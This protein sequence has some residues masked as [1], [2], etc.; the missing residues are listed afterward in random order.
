MKATCISALLVITIMLVGMSPSLNL[1]PQAAAQTAVKR[2]VTMPVKVV[3]VGVDPAT[4]DTSYI[5]WNMNLPVATYNQVLQPGPGG[6][7]TGVVFNID[8]SFTFAGNDFKTKLQSY[9]KSIQVNKHGPNPFFNYYTRS[10]EGYVST[11]NYYSVDY[12]TYDANRVENWLYSNQQDVGGFPSNGWTLMFLNLTELPSYDFQNY[13]DFLAV[14]HTAQPNG[15]AHYYSVTYTDSDLGYRYRYRDFMTG[16]GGV[17]RFWFDDLSAGPSFWTYPEDLSVQIA[18]EDNNIDL[19]SSYGRNWFTEY[20]ADYIWQATW[21]LVT[22]FFEYDPLY[23]EKYSFHVH[24]FDFRTDSEKQDVDI[25]STIDTGKIKSAYQDLAPYSTI[26]VSVKFDDTSQYQDLRSIIDS[27]Y[28]YT[29][30]FTFGVSGQPLRYGIVD[31]RPVY[32]YLQDHLSTLEPNYHRDRSE[33]TVPVYAFAFSKNTLFTFTYKWIISKPESDV[34]ALLG[35]ALGDV[36]LVS[37][38]QFEFQRGD[39]V[40]PQQPGKGEGITETV[41]HEAGHMLGAQHPHNFGPVGDFALTVM[42]YYTHD[43]VFGQSDK[44][45][46]RRAHVD[47]I[48]LGIQSILDQLA[49]SGGQTDSIN[50]IKQQLKDVDAKYSQMDYVAALSSVLNVEKAAKSVLSGSAILP[51]GTVVPQGVAGII[52]LVVGAAVGLVVGIVVAW[53][54]FIR[55][56]VGRQRGRGARRTSGRVRKRSG[57]K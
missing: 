48:Y 43:Y 4:V 54:V 47:Q 40:S 3:L 7:L 39:Y 19:H 14:Q 17:H 55:V 36:A 33:F 51:G 32:K 23:S 35:V 16:W 53:L 56:P 9:L 26:D 12:V 44:D 13:S 22:P 6:N 50:A 2:E 18:L 42:G 45:A 15:T 49:H 41:I 24:V 27:N 8:Y 52:Y 11:S 31:A 34:K 30:S 1:L 25:R 5:K 20:L 57:R 37:L 29:D 28:K 46:I 21:N 38:S 10:I